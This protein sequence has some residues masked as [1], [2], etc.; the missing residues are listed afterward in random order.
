[1]APGQKLGALAQARGRTTD[2][3]QKQADLAAEEGAY[4]QQFRQERR[5]EE[6]KN[7][8]AMQTL[9]GNQANMATDNAIAATNARTRAQQTSPEGVS[10]A[11]S[12]RSEASTAAKY[13]YT[14]HQ[15]RQL[16]PNGR[17]R[18]INAAKKSSRTGSDTVYTSGPFAGRKKSEIAALSDSQRQ[19]IVADYNAGKGTA[20]RPKTESAQYKADFRHKYG[21]D[22]LPTSAHNTLKNQVAQAQR[23][24]NLV[25][26]KDKKGNPITTDAV[27]GAMTSG[28]TQGIP[29]LPAVVIRAALEMKRYGH[30]LPGTANRLHRAGYSVAVLGYKTSRSTARK[31]SPSQ[32]NPSG[33]TSGPAASVPGIGGGAR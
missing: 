13:G 19:K 21:V 23:A 3:R 26:T 9:A 27:V 25:G 4:N 14:V 24:F 32:R 2:I 17:Q 20:G 1:V 7:Q 8:L 33:P 18:V 10:A 5:G 12:A 16:G 30:I 15:W 11:A 31:G 6:F 29:K 22:P 28:G